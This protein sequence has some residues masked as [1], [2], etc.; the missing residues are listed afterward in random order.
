VISLD[1]AMEYIKQQG[2][3]LKVEVST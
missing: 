1:A 3:P 2:E